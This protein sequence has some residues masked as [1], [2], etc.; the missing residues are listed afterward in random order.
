MMMMMRLLLLVLVGGLLLPPGAPEH[1][2][3]HVAG[4]AVE[5]G[6]EFLLLLLPLGLTGVLVAGGGAREGGR[7][8]E[9]PR[10]GAEGREEQGPLLMVVGWFCE[11]AGGGVA[12]CRRCAGRL[13]F[14]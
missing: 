13:G 7:E 2:A 14:L 10:A 9:E 1:A 8:G 4:L 11:G 12:R 3:R 6:G 5:R